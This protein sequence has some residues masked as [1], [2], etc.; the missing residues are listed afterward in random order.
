VD[1]FLV[2]TA[3]GV[4]F[5][6]AVRALRRGGPPPSDGLRWLRFAPIVLVGLALG[7]LLLDLEYKLHAYRFFLTFEWTSPM[8]WGSWLLSLSFPLTALWGL[9]G[10]SD[11]QARRLAAWAPVRVLHLGAFVV[12]LRRLALPCATGL[13]WTALAL[14]VAVGT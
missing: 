14:G 5:I 4:L 12:W 9:A 13:A 2:A 8:S 6:T 7:A 10:L 3:A 1:L 11:D